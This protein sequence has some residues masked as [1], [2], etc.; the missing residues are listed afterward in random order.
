MASFTLLS[1]RLP[2]QPKMWTLASSKERP[3]SL[4]VHLQQ[5]LVLLICVVPYFVDV[6]YLLLRGQSSPHC[7]APYTSLLSFCL[8]ALSLGWNS[9]CLRVLLGLKCTEMSCLE[10]IL[11]SFSNKSAMLFCLLVFFSLVVIWHFIN[12]LCSTGCREWKSWHQSPCV[13][14]R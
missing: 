7:T 10:K 6:W 11:L 5:S 8:D 3:L 9:F 2:S 14:F 1:N 12:C 13:D 4:A